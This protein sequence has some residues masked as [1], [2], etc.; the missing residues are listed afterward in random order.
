MVGKKFVFEFMM[1]NVW[2]GSFKEKGCFLV[3]LVEKV[4]EVIKEF[5][6]EIIKEEVDEKMEDILVMDIDVKM[7]DK[8]VIIFLIIDLVV[9]LIKEVK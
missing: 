7:E 9:L 1:G 6:K 2:K 5:V 3:L 8:K 4:K